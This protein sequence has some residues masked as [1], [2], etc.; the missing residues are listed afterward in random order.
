MMTGDDDWWSLM[1]DDWWWGLRMIVDEWWEVINDGD[2][3]FRNVWDT[4]VARSSG[5][6]FFETQLSLETLACNLLTHSCRPK[7]L[8]HCFFETQLSLEALFGNFL[9]HARRSKVWFEILWDTVVARNSGLKIFETRVS[10]ETLVWIFLKHACRLKFKIEKITS[11]VI[12]FRGREIGR[13]I[14]GK[15]AGNRQEIGGNSA[16]NPQIF[17]KVAL[18]EKKSPLEQ[19]SRPYAKKVALS[20]RATF[21]A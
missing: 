10:L 12:R 20:V 14:G 6:E 19:K 16:G 17:K 1:T 3:L 18:R 4:R 8:S 15:S 9:K 13:E 2:C 7:F 5:L 11:F 21:L